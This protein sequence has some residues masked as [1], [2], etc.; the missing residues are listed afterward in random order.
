MTSS[1]T[2]ATN[3]T[4]NDVELSTT[5]YMNSIN[6]VKNMMHTAIVNIIYNRIEDDDAIFN[7]YNMNNVKYKGLSNRIP[8]TH[9]LQ[10]VNCWMKDAYLAL[11]RK[12]LNKLYL[13]IMEN[14]SA[15]EYYEF[16]IKY[17]DKPKTSINTKQVFQVTEDFL[18]TINLLGTNTKFPLNT[19]CKIQMTLNDGLDLKYF[20]NGVLI[21]NHNHIVGMGS[22]D[23]GHNKL[24]LCAK[25]QI[26]D[27]SFDQ[28]SVNV[29]DDVEVSPSFEETLVCVCSINENFSGIPIIRCGMCKTYQHVPC[30]GYTIAKPPLNNYTC[31]YCCKKNELV[32]H[33]KRM[34]LH[35]NNER[36]LMR[37]TIL[38]FITYAILHTNITPQQI[39][40]K[41]SPVYVKAIIDFL[42]KIDFF[43]LKDNTYMPIIHTINRFANGVFFYKISSDS[44]HLSET[45]VV[46]IEDK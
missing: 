35:A 38:R 23:T 29:I 31:W 27:E 12:K 45:E 22:I 17:L 15:S 13:V 6:F 33:D 5:S 36:T 25:G 40:D 44:C 7:S 24:R 16:T 28:S 42:I 2:I 46:E 39:I 41:M 26:F 1:L 3:V 20:H 21:Q 14:N 34:F 30:I 18:K 43:H 11:E 37:S 9:Q 10:R 8:K 19:E 32:S 4:V